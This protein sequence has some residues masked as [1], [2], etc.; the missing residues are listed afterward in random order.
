MVHISSM[1]V[2]VVDT[3]AWLHRTS[4]HPCRDVEGT[5]LCWM[6]CLVPETA[7]T[8]I[9][10]PSYTYPHTLCLCGRG[11]GLCLYLVLAWVSSDSPEV[12]L[13]L[14]MVGWCFILPH[15]A[16]SPVL[17][18]QS[19]PWKC[20]FVSLMFALK[21]YFNWRLAIYISILPTTKKG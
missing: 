1:E 11:S 15:T 6:P 9:H 18:C 7:S 8:L 4:W 12:L 5:M 17:L 16:L 21:S 13:T 10:V 3:K 2:L 20:S 19:S 14:N